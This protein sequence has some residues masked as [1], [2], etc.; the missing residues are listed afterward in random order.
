MAKWSCKNHSSYP[1]SNYHHISIRLTRSSHRNHSSSF[2]GSFLCRLIYQ[3]NV[4][5]RNHVSSYFRILPRMLIH[6]AFSTCRCHCTYLLAMSPHTMF[7]FN[8][9][10]FLIQIFNCLSSIRRMQIRSSISSFRIHLASLSEYSIAPHT[11]LRCSILLKVQGLL[12][13]HNLFLELISKSDYLAFSTS[14]EFMRGDLQLWSKIFLLQ[15][16]N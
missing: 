15:V 14:S 4:V 9:W 10:K 12:V 2:Y 7:R 8:L 11:D 16:T 3:V 6:Q 1:L 5:Y 13:D